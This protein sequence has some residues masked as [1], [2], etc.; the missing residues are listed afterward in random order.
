MELRNLA[1]RPE[2]IPEEVTV[3]LDGLMI[4]VRVELAARTLRLDEVGLL[5]AGQILEL[6]CTATDLVNLCVEGHRIAR[7][8]LVDIEGHLGVRLTQVLGA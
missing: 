4:T 8:E 5:R 7:G 6:G 1:E 3:L 2:E